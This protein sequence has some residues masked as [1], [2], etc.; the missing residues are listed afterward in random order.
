MPRT[1]ATLFTALAVCACAL[2][3]SASAQEE[4]RYTVMLVGNNA[5]LQTSSVWPDGARLFTFEYTDRGRGPRLTTAVRLDASGLPVSLDTKG[6]DYLKA[7]V[8]ESFTFGGGV[9]RWKNTAE[10]GEKRLASNAFYN[11][12]NGAPEELALLARAL[13]RSP[14]KRLPLLPDG[15]AGV[16]RTGELTLKGGA[17]ERRV[18]SYEVSGLGF[19]PSTVWLDEDG[20]FFASVSGWLSVIREGWESGAAALLKKQD[21]LEAGRTSRLARALTRRPSKP[22]AFTD[23]NLFDAETGRTL[24]NMTVVVEGNRIKAVGRAR[25]VK[26]PKDAEVI[27]ARGKTLMPGLWD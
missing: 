13:L 18:V 17:G 23:A 7:P 19:T 16:E 8:A 26:V 14:D 2:A 11:S 10:S 12:M 20:S 3:L 1:P 15:E 5:G 6:N 25:R 27:D 21:E 9:A 22:L 4:T 24:P